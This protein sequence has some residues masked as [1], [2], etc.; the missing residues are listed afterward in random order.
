MVL[1]PLWIY[2]NCMINERDG[3]SMRRKECSTSI[4]RRHDIITNKA[5]PHPTLPVT[6]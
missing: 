4:A 5:L 3:F 6:S 2:F 1:S